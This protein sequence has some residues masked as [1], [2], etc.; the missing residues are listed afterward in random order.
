MTPD[1][2]PLLSLLEVHDVLD[3]LFLAH[4]TAL[5][6]RNLPAADAWLQQF[7]TQLQQHIR[8]EETHILP[9]YG[10]RIAPPEGAKLEFFQMEHTK[11][12]RVLGELQAMLM[13]LEP[14]GHALQFGDVLAPPE[15]GAI[16]ARSVIELLD[17][18]ASFKDLFRHH[19]AR[20]RHFLYP[21]LAEALPL[22]EQVAIL[23]EIHHS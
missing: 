13:L 3:E 11:I 18:E 5:L 4:Q 20:E 23:A 2:A 6:D 7:A 17:K 12:L 1:I 10:E 21:L 16:S 15:P 8:D 19:D 14:S 9:L 22:E